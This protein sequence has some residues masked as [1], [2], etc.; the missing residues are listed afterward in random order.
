M[1]GQNDDEYDSIGELSPLEQ[2]KINGTPLSVLIKQAADLKSAQSASLR[3]NFDRLPTYLQNSI[4]SNCEVIE[5]RNKP[6]E[7]RLSDAMKFKNMGNLE[8]R[9]GKYYESIAYYEMSISV[10]R[11]INN[12][13]PNWKTEGIKDEFLQE[14]YFRSTNELERL[15]CHELLVRLYTNLAIVYLKIG[16]FRQAVLS[17]ND[18]LE[19][20]PVCVKALYLR[21]KARLG[22]KSGGSAEEILA[23]KDLK[24]ARKIDPSN[25]IIM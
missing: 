24:T 9:E 13:N 6:F 23:M 10:F 18:A 21:S 3:K 15:K 4:F 12:M 1:I 19:L 17:C 8:V 5:A 7:S 16:Y 2:T 11:W 25:D 14:E 22:P 20:D